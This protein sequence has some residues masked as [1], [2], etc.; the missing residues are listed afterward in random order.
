MQRHRVVTRQ[1]RDDMV[2]CMCVWGVLGARAR[3]NASRSTS[4]DAMQRF[5][6]LLFFFR[7]NVCVWERYSL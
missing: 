5:L 6:L 7:G 1:S 3:V 2:L 4:G